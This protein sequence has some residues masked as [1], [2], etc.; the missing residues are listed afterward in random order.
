MAHTLQIEDT[1][2]YNSKDVAFYLIAK[3]NERKVGI[4]VTKVQKL[5]YIIYGTYLRVYGQRL[6][7]EHPKAWPYGPVFP[8]TR[9]AI[10]R[11]NC[12][13]E[14]E[15]PMESVLDGLKLDEKLNRVFDFAFNYF[16][17]WNSG[18]LTEWSHRE[19]SP[20]DITTKQEGFKWGNPIPDSSILDFFTKL[21]RV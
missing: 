21:V 15:Y 5:L 1:Y 17:A 8:K 12:E 10:L 6:L 2:V 20:W 7:D 16:G 4:N 11:L 18:Q 14:L 9:T 13:G 3:A 19:G